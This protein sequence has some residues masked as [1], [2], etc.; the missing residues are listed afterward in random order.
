MITDPKTMN[1][2]TIGIMNKE[3]IGSRISGGITGNKMLIKIGST[4][5][6]ETNSKTDDLIVQRTTPM[7]RTMGS[8]TW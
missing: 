8:G 1:K 6:L 5:L 4:I 2:E 7:T 3:T